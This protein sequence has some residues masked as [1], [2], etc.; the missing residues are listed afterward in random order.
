MVKSKYETLVNFKKNLN[1]PRHSWFNIK[2]GYSAELIDV[3]IKELNIKKNDVVLDPFSGSGTTVLQCSLKGIKS[4]G[5]EVNPF[6]FYLS[7]VKSIKTE[8]IKQDINEIEKMINLNEIAEKPKLSISEKLFDKQLNS[9]LAVKKLVDS[10]ENSYVNQIMNIAFL[11]S[12][13]ACSTAKKD[14]NGLRYPKNKIPKKIIDE[15]LVNLNQIIKDI[16]NLKI[17]TSPELI[18]GN[19]LEVISSKSFQRKYADKLSLVVFSPPYANCFD[20]TEVYKTEL[21]FGGFIKSYEDLK[22]LRNESMSSHLNKTFSE[23]NVKE[24]QTYIK[25]IKQKKLWSKKII[26]M[27]N[28]YFYEMECLLIDIHKLLKKNAN[29]VIIVGNSSYGNVVVPT[30]KIFSK[31]AKRLGFSSAKIKVARKLGTSSQQYKSV[32]NPEYLRESLVYLKK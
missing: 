22:A 26:P 28:N 32:D 19:S 5:I 18:K 1:I 15:F 12:L 27:L 9:V 10:Q 31:M 29:C 7:S 21:W 11:C 3:L 24:V 20:Y 4:I 13:D 6:L 30:D 16:Q 17:K 23:A 14:G 25:K 2:E 8:K